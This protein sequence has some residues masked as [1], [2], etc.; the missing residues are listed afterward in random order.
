[1]SNAY[2]KRV[3]GHPGAMAPPLDLTIKVAGNGSYVHV[4]CGKTEG[5][6]NKEEM[7]ELVHALVEAQEIADRNRT[8][9]AA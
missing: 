6:Y 9:C 4:I 8:G 3:H 5:I 7:V 2:F 1:M